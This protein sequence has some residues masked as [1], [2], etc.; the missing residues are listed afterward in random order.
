MLILNQKCLYA[1]D[2]SVCFF[3]QEGNCL[4]YREVTAHVMGIEHSIYGRVCCPLP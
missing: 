2:F 1:C 3:I 4:L